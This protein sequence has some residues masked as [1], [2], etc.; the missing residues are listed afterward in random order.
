M[1]AKKYVVETAHYRPCYRRGDLED[2]LVYEEPKYFATKKEA[3]V[4]VEKT[5]ARKSHGDKEMTV[6]FRYTG[7]TWVHEN[8]GEECEEY[9][10]YVLKK[11]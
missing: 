3:K 7:K 9:Y 4:F 8:T 10:R 5:G 2:E 6:F 1:A 11:L